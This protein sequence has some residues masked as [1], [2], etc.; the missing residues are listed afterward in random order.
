MENWRDVPGFEGKY[1]VSISTKEGKCRSLNLY[2]HK[3]PKLLSNTPGKRDGRINWVLRKNGKS[4]C[5]Q[6]AVWIA[7]T[8][9]EMVEGEWFPGA[10]IDHKDTNAM[11]NH[12][13][14]LKWTSQKGNQNNPLTKKH[15]SMA[16]SG[17]T[18]SKE[19]VEHHAKSMTNHPSLSIRV[20]QYTNNGDLVAIYDSINE[21]VRNV[22]KTSAG[23][24]SNCCRNL[25]K[26][27]TSGGFI[28]KYA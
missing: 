9:P 6:A 4:I 19:H 21:A 11:N 5:K 25:P 14:N 8:Y 18:H 28:W 20:A 27:K 7:L 10:T 2:S 23:A 12:P 17:K 26:Y 22:S 1:Q 3:E 13:S 16:L 24:I 15:K